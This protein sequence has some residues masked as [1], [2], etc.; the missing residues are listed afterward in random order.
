MG[1]LRVPSYPSWLNWDTTVIE[2][3]LCF[4]FQGSYAAKRFK[5]LT[6]LSLVRPG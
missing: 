4:A 6:E 1:F 2:K 5:V 3:S